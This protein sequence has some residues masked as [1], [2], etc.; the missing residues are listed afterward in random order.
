MYI[1]CCLCTEVSLYQMFVE[2]FVESLFVR[3]INAHI[4]IGDAAQ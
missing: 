2:Q 3:Y 1:G 4:L